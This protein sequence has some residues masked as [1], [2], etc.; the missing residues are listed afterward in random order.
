MKCF[1]TA[2]QEAALSCLRPAGFWDTKNDVGLHF[3]ATKL[4]RQ[5]INAMDRA[6]KSGYIGVVWAG[7]GHLDRS[8]RKRPAIAIDI[9]AGG[10]QAKADTRK[11][12]TM[13]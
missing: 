13:P 7:S 10:A 4:P 6:S 9:G 5:K 12:G 8:F 11:T 1:C 3:G 2:A